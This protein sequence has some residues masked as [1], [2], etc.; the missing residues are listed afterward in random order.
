MESRNGKRSILRED[1]PVSPKMSLGLGLS[2]YFIIAN[3][4]HPSINTDTDANRSLQSKT[5]T[6]APIIFSKHNIWKELAFSV[7]RLNL[8]KE[9]Y[10][11]DGS[12]L[13]ES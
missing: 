3:S 8:L 9:S 1:S 13:Y 11:Q 4:M 2:L 6:V 10:E 5:S 7:P 12:S